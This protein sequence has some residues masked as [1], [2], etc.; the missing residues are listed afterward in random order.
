MP[1]VTKEIKEQIKTLQKNDLEDIVIKFASDKENLDYLM[2]QYFDKEDG[3]KDLFDDTIAEI[4][5][6]RFKRHK[7][8]SDELKMANFLSACTKKINSFTSA[9]RNK[10]LEADL[11]LYTL[12]IAFAQTD[13]SFGTCFTAFDYR[14]GLMLKR[15][16]TIVT[17]KL[18]EDYRIEFVDQI[19]IYLEKLH[20][21]S[22]HID[23][24][25]EMPKSI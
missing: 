10:K 2:V 6:L 11:L 16:I 24:I 3:E 15:L 12:E 19:N 22:E 23:M 4:N 17:T 7:G 21:S 18:H 1:R 13:T 5:D 14:V 20:R 9:C 25:Y 8:F